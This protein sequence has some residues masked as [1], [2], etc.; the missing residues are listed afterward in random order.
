MNF[1]VAGQP[2]GPWVLMHTGAVVPLRC[3]IA[4]GDI[5]VLSIAHHLSLINR[6]AGATVRPCSVA[7]HSLLVVEIVQRELGVTRS[8]VLLAALLHDAHEAWLGDISTPVKRALGF[9]ARDLEATHTEQVQRAFGVAR[10]ARVFGSLIKAADTMALATEAR[11]LLP[12]S[13]ARDRLL[14][15]LGTDA[16]AQP[17]GWI[18]L[19]DRSAMTWTDWRQAWLDAYA[20]YR[21]GADNPTVPTDTN[22]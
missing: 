10:A 9:E 11:D 5:S 16:S 18:D 6:W 21:P 17:V 13:P 4:S 2:P 12:A 19:R 14:R 22:T 8:D 1:V 20:C 7:E 15:E 3:P